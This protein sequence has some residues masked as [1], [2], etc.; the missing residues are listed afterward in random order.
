ME[1][2]H[3]TRID[4]D[5][6]MPLG[7]VLFSFSGRIGRAT[8]WITWLS[9]LMLDSLLGLLFYGLVEATPALGIVYFMWLAISVWIALAVQA[10]RWHDRDRSA[11]MILVNLIPVVGW[12]WSLIELGFLRGT[13]EANK[14]GTGASGQIATSAVAIAAWLSSILG[15]SPAG[16][17]LGI[18]ALIETGKSKKPVRGRALASGSVILS[19]VG[20]LVWIAFFTGSALLYRHLRG[21][22]SGG[23][24]VGVYGDGKEIRVHDLSRA[25]MELKIL[26]RL[27][28]QKLSAAGSR[29]ALLWQLLDGDEQTARNL[30]A[31]L[32]QA[33]I[34]MQLDVTPGEIDGFFS[35][36]KDSGVLYWILLGA[37]ARDAGTLVSEE[38]A[39]A[40][41][42]RIAPVLHP[43]KPNSEELAGAVAKMFGVPPE[44]ILQTLAY[45]MAILEHSYE[46]AAGEIVHAEYVEIDATNLLDTQDQLSEEEIT[47][48]FQSYRH[49]MA[50]Q[51]TLRQSFRFWVHASHE[52]RG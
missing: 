47:N 50:G 14:Y 45:F 30:K 5:R 18:I 24:L 32:K 49:L 3:V 27:G 37:E 10:K 46:A 11:W 17:V 52:G 40:L 20:L 48:Q 28:I 2:P 35:D 8:F 21:G 22:D 13:V 41:L 29:P 6:E 23:Q 16:L 15:V 12:I 4:V 31:Q 38:Q 33:A 26:Q 39:E 42:Q 9:K 51:P 44:R 7:R 36:E 43:G 25:R 1:V 34:S 19:A